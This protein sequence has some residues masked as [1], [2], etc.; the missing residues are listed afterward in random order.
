MIQ[1]FHADAV[2]RPLAIE[3]NQ[4]YDAT[5]IIERTGGEQ[6]SS[7]PLG[8]FP[9]S[10]DAY[11]FAIDWAFTALKAEQRSYRSD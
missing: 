3:T 1:L 4:G 5:A 10:N 6:R 11:N 8:G 2:I 7:G 9:T